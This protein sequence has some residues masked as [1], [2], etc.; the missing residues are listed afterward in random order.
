MDYNATLSA[1]ML[2]LTYPDYNFLMGLSGLIVGF[3]F[4]IGV[5]IISTRT[6]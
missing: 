1:N 2:G 4:A 3:V 5:T 6:H